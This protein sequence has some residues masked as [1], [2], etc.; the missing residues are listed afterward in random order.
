D[1]EGFS[2]LRANREIFFG[3]LPKFF[4]SAIED[5]DRW[6]GIEIAFEPD[7]D[8]CFRVRNV[9]KGAEPVEGLREKLKQLLGPYIKLA[10]KKVKETYEEESNKEKA[11]QGIHQEAE[12][13]IATVE[14]TSPKARSGRNVSEKERDTKLDELATQ[15]AE[16]PTAE[17]QHGATA[18]EIKE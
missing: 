11:T 5:I 9:K 18:E 7:L 15:V 2:I 8:E 1:N 17:G 13:I 10:R 12:R 6:H 16:T 4:P 3:V 14:P